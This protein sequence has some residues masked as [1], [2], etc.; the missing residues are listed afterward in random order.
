M[1]TTQKFLDNLV[2]LPKLW[3]LIENKFVE[4]ESG[5][6]LSTED[7]TTALKTKLE[8]IEAGAEVNQNAFATVNVGADSVTAASK[9]G[10]FTL[11]EGANV[12]L[13]VTGSTITIAATDTTYSEATT[14]AAGLMSASDKSKLDGLEAGAEVNVIETV[15]VNGSALTPDN[16]KAVDVLIAEGS[17]DKAISVN[18]AAV[19]VHGLGTASTEDVAASI[20]DSGTGLTTSDQVY[21]FVEGKIVA[22]V[23]DGDTTHVPTGDAVA[24]AIAAAVSSAYV[25]KGSVAVEADLPSSGQ[26]TGDVY[27]IVAQSS[28]GEAGMNVAWN[29][30]A[31]DA[32]GGSIIMTAMTAAEI[33]AICV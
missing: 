10:S 21:D 11:A 9:S 17:T 29:G 18:G 6:G 22:S 31:W 28:Y 33:E 13:S 32:L 24:D 2:G 27:N 26:T 7:F 19:A 1:A 30:S 23:T 5:K 20:A 4:Q 16:N 8:G 3:E 15:K 25:Y 12:D 14:S